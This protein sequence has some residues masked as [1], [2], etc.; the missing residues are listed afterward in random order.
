MKA[1]NDIMDGAAHFVLA[2]VLKKAGDWK[3][4]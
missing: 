2:D 3:W 4:T 1:F